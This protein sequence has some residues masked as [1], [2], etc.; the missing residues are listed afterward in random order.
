MSDDIFDVPEDMDDG[1][2]S[3]AVELCD[4]EGNELDCIIL[5][6]VDYEGAPYAVMVEKKDISEDGILSE[7][8]ELII[9]AYRPGEED[10]ETQLTGVF[11]GIEDDDVIDAVYKLFTE[12]FEDE[13]CDDDC[14]CGEHHHGDC[15]C[16]EEH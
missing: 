3:F 8:A 7:D 5:D 6:F 11:E 14:D 16:G 2:F 9:L 13:C 15:G 4:D 12:G 1:L 10:S